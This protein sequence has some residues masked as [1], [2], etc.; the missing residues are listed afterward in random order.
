[1]LTVARSEGITAGSPLFIIV[2]ALLK[3]GAPWPT[4]SHP[5]CRTVPRVRAVRKQTPRGIAPW[6]EAPR[7]SSYPA[8]LQQPGLLTRSCFAERT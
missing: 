2:V 7:G 8:T 6:P 4:R 3:A 1:V 5:P